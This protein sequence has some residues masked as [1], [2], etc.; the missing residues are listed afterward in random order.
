MVGPFAV[1]LLSVCVW[2]VCVGVGGFN[3]LGVLAS[4]FDHARKGILFN[5][6]R[7]VAVTY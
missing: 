5:N 3:K 4:K 7:I 6:D 1:L 2:C